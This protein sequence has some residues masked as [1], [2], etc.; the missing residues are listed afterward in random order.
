M[1]SDTLRENK[2]L[3]ASFLIQIASALT[4]SSF[5]FSAKYHPWR[6]S[7]SVGRFLLCGTQW[8]SLSPLRRPSIF[9]MNS[10]LLTSRCSLLCALPYAAQLCLFLSRNRGSSA[11][12][13]QPK[14]QESL[15][16]GAFCGEFFNNGP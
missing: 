16:L 2:E 7:F 5:S 9:L 4:T 11:E 15:A 13:R 1:R 8:F 6:S 3:Y 12:E 14:E 10:G